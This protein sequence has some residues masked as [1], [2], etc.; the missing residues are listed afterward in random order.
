[1]QQAAK[2]AAEARKARTPVSPSNPFWQLQEAGSKQIE[3]FLKAF[4]DARDAIAE[5]TFYGVFGSPAIQ[6]A[7]RINEGEMPVRHPPPV[8]SDQIAARDM[9]MRAYETKLNAGTYDDALIRAVLYILGS[10]DA[11]NSR[12]G[13]ALN[14][15]RKSSSICLCRISKPSSGP[16]PGCCSFTETGHSR[17]CPIWCPRRPSAGAFAHGAGDRSGRKRRLRG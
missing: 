15:A 17:L 11:I 12:T 9:Q 6:S 8:T 2:L 4:C 7:L 10:G 14:E 16:K 13:L 3:A 5:N 1:M